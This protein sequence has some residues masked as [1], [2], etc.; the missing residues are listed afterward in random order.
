MRTLFCPLHLLA[1]AKA[2]ANHLVDRRFDKPRTDLL[3]IAVAFAIVG[4]EAL[5]VR[6]V[7]VEL[8]DGF[9]ELPG[10]DIA[11]GGHG[12]VQGP[13]RRTAPLAVAL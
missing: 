8:L 12:S 1:L 6:D 13:S 9:Q 7:G 5:V 10:G 4:N 11:T 2:L 3:P